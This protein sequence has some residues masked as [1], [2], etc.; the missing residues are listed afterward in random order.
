MIRAATSG[1][2]ITNKLIPIS[3]NKFNITNT[4]PPINNPAK[5]AS[6]HFLIIIILLFLLVDYKTSLILA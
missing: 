3:K 1:D 4:K 5:I 2:I 6:K